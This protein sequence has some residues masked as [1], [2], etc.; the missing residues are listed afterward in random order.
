MKIIISVGGRFHAFNLTQQ[1][2]KKNYLER[3]ITSYPKFEVV[4]YGIPK[5]KIRTILIK[6]ILERSWRKL[7]KILRNFYNPQYLLHEIFDKAAAKKLVPADIFVGW[8]SFSLHSMMKAKEMGMKIILDEGSSHIEYRRDIV[9]EEYEKFG[10][11]PELPHSKIAEKELKEYEEADY[12]CVS[13]LFAKRT[14]LEKGISENKIIHVPYGVD[15][16]DFRQ[17][18]KNDN[19]FRVIFVGGMA[20]RKGVH[21]LLQSFSELNLPNSELLLVGS[22]TDEIK[23]FFKKYEGKFRWAGTVPQKNLYKYYSQSSVFVL[24]SIEDGFGMVIIQA[25]A[26]GLPVICTEN[27]GGPDIVRNGKDGFIIPIRD[28]EKLKEKLLYLYNNKKILKQMSQSA[29]E[30]VSKGF[31]WDVYG[32]KIVRAYKRVLSN[33]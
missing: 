6:E 8:A 28:I 18:P 14:F 31:T 15:L 2:L 32:N 4:K 5:E 29:K 19:V 21:Y 27:T 17:I 25:M 3:L 16:S 20:L 26:C 23:P 12:I 1:L 11:K 7:P 13:S 22:L 33:S 10:I 9:K 24:N 30:R